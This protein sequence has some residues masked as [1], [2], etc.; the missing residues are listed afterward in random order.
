MG[1]ATFFLMHS[2]SPREV[3]R[4][5]ERLAA[6]AWPRPVEMPEP[7]IGSEECLVVCGGF[8]DRAVGTLSRV[9]QH[10]KGRFSL[11]I[12]EY[13]P[14]QKANRVDQMRRIAKDAGIS[15]EKFRYDRQNPAG[16][17]EEIGE[18]SLRFARVN[19]DISGMSRLLIVQIVVA[20]IRRRCK[21]VSIL[22]SQAQLYAPSQ[23][24]FRGDLERLRDG[25]SMSYLS[26]GI[27]E[28]AAAPELSSVAM[29]GAEVR[30]IAFPSFDP[31]QLTNLVQELQPTYADF[32]FGVSP[33]VANSWRAAAVRA[34]N[35]RTLT[36]I[37]NR[38]FH[39]TS[40][41]DYRCTLEALF[42]IYACRSMFDRIV[43]SPTGSKMQTLAVGLFCGGLADVQVVYPTP[44]A[45]PEP[46]R[47]TERLGAL[48][49]V[50]LPMA[51][52]AAAVG[53]GS[54]L[55]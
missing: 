47:Y 52:I 2:N 43:I 22:Y 41:F 17:G 32:I 53:D 38:R 45:F 14:M 15:T 10:A 13:L 46:E 23:D 8:E 49:K 51:I 54:E 39:F 37:T 50:D 40:T 48:Y 31:D 7:S 25:R 29:A 6:I 4:T 5:D 42:A 24:E 11:A 1:R 18:Y 55:R 21:N 12:V 44:Q 20:L 33:L 30:L 27:F 34:L 3:L 16:M 36:E 26:S 19:V 9:C 28:I 35:G